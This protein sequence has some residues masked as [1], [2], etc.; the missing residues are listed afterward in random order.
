MLIIPKLFP[1]RL[2]GTGP[3]AKDIEPDKVFTSI[4]LDRS[5]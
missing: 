3:K 2:E 4:Y 1:K 5:L